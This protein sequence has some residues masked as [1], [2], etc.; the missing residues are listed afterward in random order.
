MT[1]FV[2]SISMGGAAF[3]ESPIAELQRV[4]RKVIDCLDE[5]RS[6]GVVRDSNGNSCGVWGFEAD[7][8]PDGASSGSGGDGSHG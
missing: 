8:H 7:S 6:E 5:G 4:L 2:M 3:D 1:S